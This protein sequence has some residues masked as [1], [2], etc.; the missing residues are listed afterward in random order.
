MSKKKSDRSDRLTRA[1]Q[2]LFHRRGV[3][4]VS[5]RDVAAAARVP[6]GGVFYHFPSKAALVRAAAE[7]RRAEVEALLTRLEERLA[8][9]AERVEALCAALGE[10]ASVT[11]RHGCPMLRMVTELDGARGDEAEARAAMRAA[12]ADIRWFVARALRAAGRAPRIAERESARFLALWQGGIALALAGGGR[13][14]LEEELARL[15]G[16][17]LGAQGPRA[18]KNR[19]EGAPGG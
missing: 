12:L 6:P 13:A 16:R 8:D 19:P 14:V 15:P 1:A 17:V 2:R 9:P 18:R 5:L 3:H 4:A 10:G 7:T 11:A